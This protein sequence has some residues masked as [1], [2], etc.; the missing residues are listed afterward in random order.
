MTVQDELTPVPKTRLDIVNPMAEKKKVKGL[1]PMM[2]KSR[3]IK[4]IHPD[5][6]K[7]E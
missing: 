3:E 2:T 5:I 4:W 6:V 1:I 7:D